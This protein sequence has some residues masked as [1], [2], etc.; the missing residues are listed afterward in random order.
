MFYTENQKIEA[1]STDMILFLEATEGFYFKRWGNEYHC[2]SH[3]SLVIKADRRTW[4]WNSRTLR[5]RSAIDWCMTVRGMTFTSSMQLL[6]GAPKGENKR[7]HGKKH[8]DKKASVDSEAFNYVKISNKLLELELTNTELAVITYLSTIHTDVIG[9]NGTAW[10]R[11]KQ[12]TIAAKCA[13]SVQTV[14]RAVSSLMEKGLIWRSARV[15]KSDNK[16]GT[17]CYAL[18][19]PS[20]NSGY[21]M[22]D[23]RAVNGTLLPRQLRVYLHICRCIDNRI[24][25][26]WN[27]Y[28]DLAEIIGMKRSDVVQIVGELCHLHYIVKQ[29][30]RQRGNRKVFT[31]NHYSLIVIVKPAICRRNKKIE[32]ALK[33]TTGNFTKTNKTMIYTTLHYTV[34]KSVCQ[35]FSGKK[36]EEFFSRGSP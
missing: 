1:R 8:N 25:Y 28:N 35:A 6:V 18:S 16:S 12:S 30:V 4:Y 10:I 20:L 11:V 23:R 33:A 5:G 2:K 26:C 13:I 14:G 34:S 29:R 32:A 21:F 17:T 36:E 15:L 9:K 27:S 31:D 3:D 7:L 22:L 24:G 19:L